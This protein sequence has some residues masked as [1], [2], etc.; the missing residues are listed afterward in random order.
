M[1]IKDEKAAFARRLNAVLDR[2]GFAEKNQGRQTKLAAM[3]GTSQKG[4]RKWLEGEAIPRLEN[5]RSIAQAFDVHMQ[6]LHYGD[7]PISGYHHAVGQRI[8]SAR[9]A[10]GWTEGDLAAA[11][12]N[13]SA[14]GIKAAGI[15]AIEHG[16]RMAISP[17]LETYAEVFGVPLSWLETGEE[18]GRY[19]LANMA[20]SG[21]GGQVVIPWLSATGSMGEGI[22]AD[23]DH[24]TL[25]SQVSVSTL[26]IRDN[27]SS[28]SSPQHLAMITGCGDSMEGTFDHGD[29]LFVDTGVDT[30]TMDAVYILRLDDDL[31]IK[32]LQ[33]KPDGS[34]LM[35]SDNAKYSPYTIENCRKEKLQVLGRIVGIWNFKKM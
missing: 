1:G 20:L 6:W 16:R 4:A 8:H 11:L 13:K 27:L 35:I 32:R 9:V 23:L 10:K 14:D 21:G 12:S 34:I 26:W 7:G 5:I 24:D 3:F 31:Y 33:R 17:A 30:I 2:Q 19:R 15:K 25:V 18:D 28:I 22:P 29:V